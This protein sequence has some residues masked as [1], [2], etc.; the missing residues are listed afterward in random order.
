MYFIS[1]LAK[2]LINK[3]TGDIVILKQAKK[4]TVLEIM[5]IAYSLD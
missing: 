1:P 5:D 2:I 3:K 4:D